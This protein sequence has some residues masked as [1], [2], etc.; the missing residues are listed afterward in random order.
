MRRFAEVDPALAGRY[1]VAL[2][3][4]VVVVVVVVL[5]DKEIAGT[6]ADVEDDDGPPAD[7]DEVCLPLPRS[8]KV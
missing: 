7:N 6:G 3:C 5:G 1:V 4:A 2:A 8:P